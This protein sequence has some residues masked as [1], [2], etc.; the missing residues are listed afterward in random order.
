[1]LRGLILFA[2]TLVVS[3][4]TIT[5]PA[6]TVC[7]AA[8]G[9]DQSDLFD[10]R[11]RTGGASALGPGLQDGM[12]AS[13]GADDQ[14]TVLSLSS[15]GQW[16]AFGAGLLEGWTRNTATPRPDFDLVTGISAGALMA[17]P[18]FVGS[19]LNEGLKIYRG[20]GEGDVS[21]SRSPFSV[22]AAPS[23]RDPAPLEAIVK[24]QITPEVVV[25]MA[26]R[27]AAGSRL[28]VAATNLDTTRLEVFSLGA[29][30]ADENLPVTTRSACIQEILLASAAV[31][32]ILPPRNINGTLYA[33]G[34]L[35]DTVFLQEVE[36]ARAE[37]EAR[38]GRD[39]QVT[40][41]LVVNGSL[42]QPTDPVEDRLLSYIG[43]SVSTLADEV[44]RD[45]ILGAI[46][47]AE[48]RDDW[49][50][51]G[52]LPGVD[53]S[54]CGFDKPPELTFEPCLTAALYDAGV[55]TGGKTPIPWMDSKTLRDIV[56]VLAR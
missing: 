23:L 19:D 16:G 31:P 48:T 51:L 18:A 4:C 38:T 1:M 29:I 15:G 5:R 28:L 8:G 30:A 47:F 46:E 56:R 26:E 40:A 17:V 10:E 55:R 34:G 45:S 36:T 52:L 21:R 54:H 44:L 27:E 14:L 53:F 39:L 12:I 11:L 42:E 20:I 32:A 7:P 37:V 13:V 22:L 49:T 41:Y 50:L 24:A 35:R 9:L 6:P 3:A 2:A 25:R 43:R 33:D